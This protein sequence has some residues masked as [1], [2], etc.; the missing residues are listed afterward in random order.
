MK[1][2]K[3]LFWVLEEGWGLNRPLGGSVCDCHYFGQLA[4]ISSSQE[5]GALHL[6]D[7]V[8]YLS[9]C[10]TKT[11][12]DSDNTDCHPEHNPAPPISYTPQ[13]DLCRMWQRLQLTLAKEALDFTVCTHA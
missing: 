8:P 11:G 3:F 1:P 10:E 6:R 12:P 7:N 13:P 4:C 9:S 2:D 5:V